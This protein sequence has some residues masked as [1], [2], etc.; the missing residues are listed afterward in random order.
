MYQQT[1]TK[2]RR[3]WINYETGLNFKPKDLRVATFLTCIWPEAMDIFNF[4]NETDKDDIDIVIDK[5]ETFCVGKTKV[6]FERYV[7]HTCVQGETETFD[8]YLSKVRKF[9]RT[10]SYGDLEN[11][12]ITD[13]L[14]LGIRDNGLRKRLLQDDKLTL[15]KCI[16]MCRAAEA[17]SSKVKS[18][19][20]HASPDEDV[21]VVKPKRKQLLAKNDQSSKKKCKYCGKNCAKGKCPAFGQKCRSCGK[22]NHFASECKS[23]KHHKVKSERP[24]V[25]HLNLSSSSGSE[26]DVLMLNQNQKVKTKIFANMLLIN[27]NKTVR[28]QLDSG[29]TANILPRLYAPDE[30]KERTNI[31]LSMYDK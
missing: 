10:C 5:F 18:L 2:F 6:T 1:G 16:D 14:V 25:R 8:T 31:T 30:I 27:K 26:E 13:R 15:D 9:A 4:A 20:K 7:F 28:F 23:R 17:S 21:Q 22:F 24:H 11:E 19:S 12:L 29:A 3:G